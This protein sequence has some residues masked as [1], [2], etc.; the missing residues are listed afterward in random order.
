MAKQGYPVLKWTNRNVKK[1][2]KTNIYRSTNTPLDVNDLPFPHDVVQ[3]EKDYYIDRD[4]TIG[5]TYYYIV[6]AV[7]DDE[8]ELSAMF[9]LLFDGEFMGTDVITEIEGTFFSLKPVY[10]S[11]EDESLD[12]EVNTFTLKAVSLTE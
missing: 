2:D 6:G 11:F 12:E 9:E 4:M 3:G 7:K 10:N 1:I 5:S 8:E